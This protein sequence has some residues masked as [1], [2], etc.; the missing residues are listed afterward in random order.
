[1]IEPFEFLEQLFQVAVER[2]APATLL[3][4]HLPVPPKGNTW[5]LGAGKA[6]V[7]MAMAFEAAWDAAF[8]SAPLSGV[9]VAPYGHLPESFLA[10]TSRIEVMQASH[11]VPDQR[12][13]DAAQKML[14]LA[15]RLTKDDLVVV[16]ISGGGS[17]LLCLPIE[18]L[19]LE[20][21]QGVNRALLQSGASID[22]MNIVRKH[23]SQ[24]KGGRL[25]QALQPAEVLTLC[26][27][28]VPGDDPQIIASGP[29]VPDQSTSR[30]ACDILQHYGIALPKAVKD[31]LA[32]GELETP[33]AES[34]K[35]SRHQVRVI[36]CPNDAL[37]AAAAHA[38]RL[39]IEPYLLADDVQGESKDVAMVHAS[40]ARYAA[41]GMGPF[42]KPCVLLSGGETTVTIEP[43]SVSFRGE[44]CAEEGR[45]VRAARGGRAGEFCLALAKGLNATPGVW[46]LAADTDGIDGSSSA[47]GARVGPHTLSKSKA[48]GLNVNEHATRHDSHG[49]FS[50]LS[51]LVVTGPTLTNVN[52]FRAILIV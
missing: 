49:F 48:L 45:E 52:D 10:E 5:V 19:T 25:L 22:E 37:H 8:P 2:A 9:V 33:K 6:S 1:M 23:L 36:A 18:G 3:A 16:L 26:I 7:S 31:A 41:Q 43:K 35:H 15:K 28:D 40:L 34:F 20:D 11:P 17:S 42:K 30:Q 39:G 32:V 12:S 44:P 50:A 51:D 46:A 47:A 4:A 29:T 14:G 24:I 27:S 21:K 13:I 38:K